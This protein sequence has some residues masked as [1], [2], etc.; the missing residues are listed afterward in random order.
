VSLI[1][2]SIVFF[3]PTPCQVISG[4]S[5]EQFR[6]QEKR[7]TRPSIKYDPSEFVYPSYDPDGRSV[8]ICVRFPASLNHAIE[9]VVKSRKFP[10]EIKDNVILW[11]LYE[12]L[13]KLQSMEACVS[14]LPMLEITVMLARMDFDL[15]RFQEF[16]A[17]LDGAI[18]RLC[19]S[20]YQTQTARRVVK[21][22]DRN[23]NTQR[24]ACNGR[25]A[26]SNSASTDE[27]Q[28]GRGILARISQDGLRFC[29]PAANPVPKGWPSTFVF[30]IRPDF[31]DS[32]A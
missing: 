29:E 5:I 12:G 22:I 2:A 3:N 18:L 9:S 19:N 31:L 21:A 25:D 28:G 6:N 8:H 17:K 16:F 32:A 7:M 27:R 1:I 26:N 14:V 23:A 15:K 4:R 20:G 11:C 13:R 30:R 10:F 24:R